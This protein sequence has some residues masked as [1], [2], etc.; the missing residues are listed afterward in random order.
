MGC[1]LGFLFVCFAVVV[2]GFTNIESRHYVH[3]QPS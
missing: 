3:Y 2:V 1:F